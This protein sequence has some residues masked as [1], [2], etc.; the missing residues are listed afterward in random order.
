MNSAPWSAVM[1]GRTNTLVRPIR[2]LS[3]LLNQAGSCGW[4]RPEKETIMLR[5]VG[6]ALN[7]ECKPTPISSRVDGGNFSIRWNSSSNQTTLDSPLPCDRAARLR[8]LTRALKMRD[9]S[10][11]VAILWLTPIVRNSL[12]GKASPCSHR[13][14]TVCV[15]SVPV[16]RTLIALAR[17]GDAV[18]SSRFNW[19]DAADVEIS[20]YASTRSSG[21][22]P[23]AKDR[24]RSTNERT[25]FGNSL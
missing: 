12:A 23:R 5:P 9:A 6:Q 21:W 13:I 24:Y 3:S 8:R 10:S 15:L 1:G 17:S 14:A 19:S 11:L 18:R 7:V 20:R 22:I 25:D 4:G 16:T 2:S